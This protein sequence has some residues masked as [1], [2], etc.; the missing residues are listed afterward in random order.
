MKGKLFGK[1]CL[2]TGA[3]RGI[4][5]SI[6]KRLL[7]SD[8][9]V[10]ASAS[11]NDGL[12]ALQAEFYNFNQNLITI[13]AD[14]S[15]TSDV[16]MLCRSVT[17]AV[18]NI[19]ILINNAGIL[20]L[21]DLHNCSEDLLRKSFEVNFFSHQNCAS[22]AVKIMKKQNINGCL[23]FNISKQSVNPGKNFGPYGLPKSALLNLC[24]QYAVDYGSYG[25][26]SNGVN[27]DRIRSGL[28]TDKMIKNRAKARAVTTDSYMRGNLLL[29]EVKAEDVAK[30]FF[31]LA[32]SKKTSGV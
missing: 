15:L 9:V 20:H 5:K 18:G 1:K 29:D 26:R 23:L 19:D 30:A 16:D 24:K 12:I 27:A 32:I 25:I 6:V 22:E 31:H 3:S 2:V 14:L 4:G 8:A 7:E 13:R 10:V 21:E 17:T 11:N 28:M